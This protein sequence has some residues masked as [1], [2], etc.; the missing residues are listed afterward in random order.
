MEVFL[1]L[2][3]SEINSSVD[4]QESTM[5]KLAA[6]KLSREELLKWLAGVVD[7]VGSQA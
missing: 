5:M 6:S 2:N 7:D 1:L 4:E 3:G